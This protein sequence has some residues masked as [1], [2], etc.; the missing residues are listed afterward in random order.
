MPNQGGTI[1]LR[2][3]IIQDDPNPKLGNS[4]MEA[5]P[6]RLYGSRGVGEA[7]ACSLGAIMTIKR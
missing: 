7:A 6:E 3:L 4:G 2:A 5:R 1:P